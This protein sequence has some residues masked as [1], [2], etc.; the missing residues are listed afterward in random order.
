[1]SESSAVS[2]SFLCFMFSLYKALFNLD[3]QMC[4]CKLLI[5]QK[6]L[7]LTYLDILFPYVSLV[8]PI[9]FT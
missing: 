4:I 5:Q 2:Y 8:S 6:S 9:F 1:M 3:S 7:L